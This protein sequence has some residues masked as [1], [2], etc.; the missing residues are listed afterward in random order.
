MIPDKVDGTDGMPLAVRCECCGDLVG[1][2]FSVGG[3]PV[4]RGYIVCCECQK[5]SDADEAGRAVN[6]AVPMG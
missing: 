6:Q 5:A 1:F 3:T 4:N 2:T